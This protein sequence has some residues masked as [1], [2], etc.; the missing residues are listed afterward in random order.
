MSMIKETTYSSFDLERGKCKSCNE[1]TDIVIGED[2][3][4]D[5]IQD[6]EFYEATMK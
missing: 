4:P 2:R 3:C 5:C 1:M 6:Q